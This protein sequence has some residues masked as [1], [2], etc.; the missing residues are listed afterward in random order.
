MTT[1]KAGVAGRPVLPILQGGPD[2]GLVE[3]GRELAASL[4]ELIRV[5]Q[6][7][8]RDRA[9]CY[10]VSVS[11]CYALKSIRQAGRATVNDLAAHLYL[12]KSTASRL[13]QSLVEKGYVAREAD[14][15]DGRVVNL[16]VTSEGAAL[17]AAIEA[18]EAREYAE[19]LVDFDPAVR[20]EINRLVRKLG[21][22]FASSV[23]ASGGSC[24]V[25]K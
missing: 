15:E 17:C 4:G 19:L 7:R 9:C 14:P 16:V 13:A 11:Q 5:V 6:F 12:D 1:I 10:D 25:V 23:D 22:C 18:G 8:D 20:S 21:R 3:D 24:C 2:V